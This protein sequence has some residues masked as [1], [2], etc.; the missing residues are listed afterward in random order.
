MAKYSLDGKYDDLDELYEQSELD[1]GLIEDK[2][3]ITYR[4]KTIKSG[5][6]LECEIYPVWD[7]SKA[8]ARARK[9]RESRKAQNKR[10]KKR[11][12]AYKYKFYGRGYLGNVYV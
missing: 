1:A 4:T 2:H 11:Y 9:F 6:V 5:K 12:T 7:T 8:T 3:I 10:D